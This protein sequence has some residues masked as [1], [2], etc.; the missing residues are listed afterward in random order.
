MES[1]KGKRLMVLNGN[2]LTCDVVEKAKE[3]GVYT[4]VTDWHADSPAKKIADESYMVS[5]SDTDALVALAKE[6]KVDG[7]YTQYTDSSL[8][9]CLKACRA[10][11]LPFF[12]DE[13]QLERISNKELSKQLCIEYGVP[14]SKRYY[15]SE[16]LTDAELESIDAWPVLTKPVDNSGQRGITICNNPEELRKGYQFAKENSESGKVIVEEYMHGDYLVINFTL[17]NGELSLS[18]LADKPVLSEELANGNIRL[19]KGYIMPSKYLDIFYEKAFPR[20]ERLAKGLGLKNGSWS[21]ECVFRN[22]D[23][24]VFEMQFRLGGMKHHNFVLKENGIDLLE[25]HIRF[26]LTGAFEGYDVKKLDNPY[27]KRIYSSLNVLLR[28]GTITQ[29]SGIEETRNL[30]GVIHMNM[31]QKIG[32]VVEETGTVFQILNKYSLE[33]ESKEALADLIKEIYSKLS[34]LD[35]NGNEMIFDVWTDEDLHAL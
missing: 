10:M 25:M 6:R 13:I 15:L 5:I 35:E 12:V 30:P 7:I 1:L 16:E 4:I 29:I 9:Y 26:A 19:P 3:L 23:F 11:G 17:Q 22:N 8:P 33:V 21:I 18:C 27:Y 34:V 28:G 32:N 14:V 24:Y 2:F 31:M 20:F